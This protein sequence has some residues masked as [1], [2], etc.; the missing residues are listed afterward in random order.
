MSK[1]MEQAR[2]PSLRDK[3]N[4]V[5]PTDTADAVIVKLKKEGI[6]KLK[7]G[8]LGATKKKSK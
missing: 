3:I 5:T 6:K 1:T 8:K 2:L 7:V 4:A